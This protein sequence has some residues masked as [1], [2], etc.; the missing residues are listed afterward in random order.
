VTRAEVLFRSGD[1]SGARLLLERASEQGDFRAVLLLAQTFDPRALSK[2]GAHG[3]R[4]DAA[5]AEELYARA[6]ALQNMHAAA[7]GEGQRSR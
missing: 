6:R 7:V 5:K 2:I 4:G 1:V 3:I